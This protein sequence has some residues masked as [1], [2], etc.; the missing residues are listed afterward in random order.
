M[1][2]FCSL[3]VFQFYFMLLASIPTMQDQVHPSVVTFNGLQWTVSQV[4]SFLP[5]N[6]KIAVI[7]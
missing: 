7:N 4:D 1:K 6:S 2:F 3:L 5:V